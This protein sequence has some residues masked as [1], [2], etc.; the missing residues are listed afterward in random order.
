MAQALPSTVPEPPPAFLTV[1]G[2]FA[3]T[4][5]ADATAGAAN[6]GRVPK[7]ST[8]AHN[9]NHPNLIIFFLSEVPH[10]PSGEYQRVGRASQRNNNYRVTLSSQ[11]S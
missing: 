2:E 5:A 9:A 1:S 11:S 10:R 8:C 6:A 3:A 7:P 4:T